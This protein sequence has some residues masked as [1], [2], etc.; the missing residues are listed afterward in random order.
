MVEKSWL[1]QS[2]PAFPTSPTLLSPFSLCIC[3]IGLLPI[4]AYK[5]D[6]FFSQEHARLD[7]ACRL[8]PYNL[9]LSLNTISSEASLSILMKVSSLLLWPAIPVF[10]TFLQIKSS[11]PQALPYPGNLSLIIPFHKDLSVSWPHGTYP[12]HFSQNVLDTIFAVQKLFWCMYV[13][14]S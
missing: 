9:D 3:H 1:D 6:L 8:T 10:F 4:F 2:L 13:S 5:H 7:D 14:F 12:C 11:L